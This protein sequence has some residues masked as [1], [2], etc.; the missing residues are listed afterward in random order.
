MGFIFEILFEALGDLLIEAIARLWRGK[1]EVRAPKVMI[2][3][4]PR[5]L[6]R[7]IRRRRFNASHLS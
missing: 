7:R 4:E 3:P 6:D 1:R 5:R 2:K